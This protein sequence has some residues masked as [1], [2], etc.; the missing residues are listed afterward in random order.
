L[1]RKRLDSN[2]L[3]AACPGGNRPG[4][5]VFSLLAGRKWRRGRRRTH[6]QLA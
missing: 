4:P 2:G 1:F 6:A 3:L 5:P